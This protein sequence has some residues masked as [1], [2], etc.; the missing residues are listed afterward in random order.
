MIHAAMK[1]STAI[2]GSKMKLDIRLAARMVLVWLEI[3][4]APATSVIANTT[5][6]LKS[7]NNRPSG[8]IS[9]KAGALVS[10]RARQNSV[11]EVK[12]AIRG[13]TRAAINLLM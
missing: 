2:T 13:G 5:I 9:A 7:N 8:K 3:T 6:R 10:Q 4:T 11:I 1:F 12:L